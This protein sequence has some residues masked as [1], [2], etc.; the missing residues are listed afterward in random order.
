MIMTQFSLTF[1]ESEF[2]DHLSHAIDE[3][4]FKAKAIIGHDLLTLDLLI[5]KTQIQFF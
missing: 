2:S 5:F 4:T 1:S 3:I